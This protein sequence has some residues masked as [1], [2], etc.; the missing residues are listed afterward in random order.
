MAA[1]RN[2]V[3][4]AAVAS[5][6]STLASVAREID[7]IDSLASQSRALESRVGAL[8][9]NV[10][11]LNG[12]IDTLQATHAAAL[13]KVRDAEAQ[14]GQII[15]KAEQRRAEIL[16]SARSESKLIETKALA[17]A[18]SAKEAFAAVQRQFG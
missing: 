2:A 6:D 14:A 18:A 12:Q 4:A 8:Q 9:Q 1:P 16:D 3:F 5:L 13:G 7:R 10:V 17:V 15:A 11:E